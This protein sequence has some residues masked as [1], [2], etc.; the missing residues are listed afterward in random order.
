LRV[1]LSN[2]YGT[3]PITVG[4]A[5][6]ALR[7]KDDS[8]RQSGTALTFGGAPAFTIAPGA[9]AYSDPV[10]LTVPQLSDLA[11]DLFLPGDTS[12][13]APLTMHNGAFQTSYVSQ[14]GNH[15]G[16][17][18]LPTASRIQNW[19]LIHRV[20]VSAPA[21]VAGLVVF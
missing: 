19:F 6:V 10:N 21:S 9:I 20:E 3:A 8:I 18:T 13:L 12:T 4:G 2:K 5:Y 17:A 15:A 1:V 16:M 7:D 11:I 14:P